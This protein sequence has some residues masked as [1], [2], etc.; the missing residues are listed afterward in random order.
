MG[1]PHL[2]TNL[3]AAIEDAPVDAITV[4]ILALQGGYHEHKVMLSKLGCAVREIRQRQDLEQRIDALV[5]PGGESTTMG[6]LA[7]RLELLEPLREFVASGR[8]VMGTCAGLIFLADEVIGQKQGGQELVGGMDI[9]VQRNFFGSQVD[10][11]ESSLKVS[12]VPERLV[13]SVFIRAP[14]IKRT[15]PAVE[16]LARVRLDPT[17]GS[18]AGE[19]VPVAVQ[20]GNLLGLAFHPE[21]TTDDCWHAHFVRC[22]QQRAGSKKRKLQP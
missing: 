20:Q 18:E 21:L 17:A 15:G 16:V 7:R 5:I 13:P 8:A 6:H 12:F 11:F 22:A 9:T 4:G 2:P 3:C 19:E 14:A 10:S 1:L